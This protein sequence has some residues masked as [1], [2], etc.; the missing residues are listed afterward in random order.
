M[1]GDVLEFTKA[2]VGHWSSWVTGGFIIAAIW[3][4]EHFKGEALSWRFAVVVLAF[5]FLVATFRAWRDQYRGWI[6]ERQYRSRIADE[7]AT[8]RHTAQK[9]YYEWWEA[10]GDPAAAATAKKA[11]EE[12]RVRIVEKLQSEISLAQSDYFNTPKMYEPFPASRN[13]VQCPEAALINE[14]GYRVQRLGEVIQ[15][16]LPQRPLGA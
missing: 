16:I 10:C 5:C 1:L 14:F 4:Y 8:L 12:I 11:A 6:D 13:L 2:V 3:V 9:R 7:F 15:R